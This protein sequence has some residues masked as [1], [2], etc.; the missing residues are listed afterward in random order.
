M[1]KA[2]TLILCSSVVPV[3]VMLSSPAISSE[4]EC[5]VDTP[6]N[7]L[8]GVGP[9]ISSLDSLRVNA[10]RSSEQIRQESAE[11]SSSATALFG[12][13]RSSGLSA[14]GSLAGWGVWASYNRS[15]FDGDAPITG[16]VLT[17]TSYNASQNSFTLGADRLFMDQLLIGLTVSYE[18]MSA[19]TVF[20]GGVTE[21][22]GITVAPYLAYLIN[23]TFSVDFMTGYAALNYDTTRLDF[24]NASTIN[25][26]FDAHRVFAA[27][28]LNALFTPE[29]WAIAARVGYLYSREEQDD[30][31][32]TGGAG[33]ART[34]GN[35]HLDLS[36]VTIGADIAYSFAQLEP[37]FT[38]VYRND[39]GRDD[40]SSAGG[41]PGAVTSNL[42]QDDDE[43]QLGFGFRYFGNQGVTGSLEWLTTTGRDAFAA[44]SLLLTFRLDM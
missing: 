36:Q 10:A 30:Y 28:N 32:E 14:G 40:G 21:N 34:I 1:R 26:D 23:D 13:G 38:A 37:Y 2:A 33:N 18:D 35:R 20:N 44:N 6:E 15:Q 7:C 4:L 3:F 43:F 27:T 41:L 12:S 25:G 11:D 16:A 22:K 19:N 39:L 17:T 31:V 42:P 5:S 29:Q 24:T 9:A 8:D